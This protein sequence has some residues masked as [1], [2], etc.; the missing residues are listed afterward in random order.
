LSAA[1]KKL[2]GAY[3]I[4]SRT[5]GLFFG[6]A[7]LFQFLAQLLEKILAVISLLSCRTAT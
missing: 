5:L 4:T 1:V 3:R 2:T 7:V 6:A